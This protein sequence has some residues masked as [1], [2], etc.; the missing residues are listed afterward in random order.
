M[1]NSN[2]IVFKELNFIETQE[3]LSGNEFGTYSPLHVLKN[4]LTEVLL[5]TP[6]HS[7]KS[8]EENIL[9]TFDKASLERVV[10]NGYDEPIFMGAG[11]YPTDVIKRAFKENNLNQKVL[12]EK[13]GAFDVKSV[14]FSGSE[15]SE[16]SICQEF[17]DIDDDFDFSDP[18][19]TIEEKIKKAEFFVLKKF[20]SIYLKWKRVKIDNPLIEKVYYYFIV[21]NEVDFNLIIFELFPSLSYLSTDEIESIDFE[22]LLEGQSLLQEKSIKQIKEG[23]KINSF[24]YNNSIVDSINCDVS[25][26]LYKAKRRIE[27]RLRKKEKRS[28]R[29]NKTTLNSFF[30]IKL[31]KDFLDKTSL[32]Y[33]DLKIYYDTTY[34]NR[35]SEDA[36]V[37]KMKN[38]VELLSKYD[39]YEI[40][41]CDN[42][43]QRQLF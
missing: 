2:F 25:I 27:M 32:L 20:K 7:G 4:H 18:T 43:E 5:N 10:G 38:K 3:F 13:L 14:L 23:K 12:S 24:W 37:N 6:Y 34:S 9:L 21:R 39:F 33:K 1:K 42:L 28:T 40:S 41:I 8:I 16:A 22:K 31:N 26:K 30:T 29:D 11:S 17:G 35:Y 15:S 19:L 36:L